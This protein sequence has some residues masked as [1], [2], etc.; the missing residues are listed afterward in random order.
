MISLFCYRRIDG[1]SNERLW[2]EKLFLKGFLC[3]DCYWMSSV[4]IDVDVIEIRLKNDI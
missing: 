3:N 2:N 1:I 4:S